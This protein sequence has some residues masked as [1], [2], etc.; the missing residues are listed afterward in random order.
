MRY[1]Q[2]ASLNKNKKQEQFREELKSVG[3]LV[4]LRSKVVGQIKHKKELGRWVDG[5]FDMLSSESS[6]S[7]GKKVEFTELSK[8]RW[9]Q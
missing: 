1:C 7:R 8:K 6:K 4:H 9:I 5:G 3:G 2:K